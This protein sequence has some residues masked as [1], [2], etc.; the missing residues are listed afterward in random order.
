[1]NNIKTYFRTGEVNWLEEIKPKLPEWATTKPNHDNWPDSFL[2]LSQYDRDSLIGSGVQKPY[3]GFSNKNSENSCVY[4]PIGLKE[5]DLKTNIKEGLI[6]LSN[7][8]HEHQFKTFYVQVQ[9]EKIYF[10]ESYSSK[11][12][13]HQKVVD[14]ILGM[15]K[16]NTTYKKILEAIR[17]KFYPLN[18]EVLSHESDEWEIK[19]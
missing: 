1:M 3:V 14:F 2:F 9:Q 17:D 19:T 6:F 18:E 12:S 7:V 13:L 8:S 4:F 16:R 5:K 11:E 15:R 10:T